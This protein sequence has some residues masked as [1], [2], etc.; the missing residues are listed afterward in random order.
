[1]GRGSREEPRTRNSRS[2]HPRLPPLPPSYIQPSS[3]L[4]PMIKLSLKLQV[5]SNWCTTS[6]NTNHLLRSNTSHYPPI[7]NY[8]KRELYHKHPRCLTRTP[9][10][11]VLLLTPCNN[12]IHLNASRN[13]PFPI[14]PY[15][16]RIRTSLRL[17]RRICRR[18][19]RLILPS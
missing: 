7:C 17:Q 6:S 5:H 18:T 19:I 1:M 10:P 11:H 15:R 16:R 2:P 4:N 3:L 14:R 8:I 12:M 13:K 9:I